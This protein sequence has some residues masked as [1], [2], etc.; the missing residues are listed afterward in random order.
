MLFLSHI[1]HIKGS[2]ATC[3]LWLQNLDSADRP[4]LLVLLLWKVILDCAG[5]ALCWELGIAS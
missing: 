2:I 3:A 4:V 5:R 1:H